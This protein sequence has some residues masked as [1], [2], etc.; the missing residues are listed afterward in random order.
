MKLEN[1]IQVLEPIINKPFKDFLTD[2]QMK[3]IR[4]NKGLTG[5][6]IGITI[7]FRKFFAQS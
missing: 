3:G 2:E 1:A 6:V 7:R 4:I 5:T